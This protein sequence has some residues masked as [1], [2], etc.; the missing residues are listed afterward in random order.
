MDIIRHDILP[1]GT[2]RAIHRIIAHEIRGLPHPNYLKD[3]LH[4]YVV[5]NMLL[6][7]RGRWII[8]NSLVIHEAQRHFDYNKFEEVFY[9]TADITDE[10]LTELLLKF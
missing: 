3:D 8:E 10:K 7:E 9:L 5:D 2:I 6:T 4:A 1:D